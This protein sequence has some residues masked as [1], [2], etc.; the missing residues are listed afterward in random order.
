[1]NAAINLPGVNTVDVLHRNIIPPGP[2]MLTKNYG[3]KL[4]D[5][6]NAANGLVLLSNRIFRIFEEN[7][8]TGWERIPAEIHPGNGV[9]NHDYSLLT[10]TGKCVTIDFSKSETVIKQPITPTGKAISIRRGIYFDMNDWDGS[11]IFGAENTL[12]TFITDKV[13]RLL[14]DNKATNILIEKTTDFEL[15]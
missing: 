2:V 11:D 4:M 8:V 12:F 1:M 15:Y 9:I 14:I 5:L 13:R 6:V 3:S 10:I 7:N